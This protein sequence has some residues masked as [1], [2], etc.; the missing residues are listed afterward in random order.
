MEVNNGSGI[1]Q[2]FDMEKFFDKVSLIDTLNAL[3][4][5]GD[6][7]EKDYRMWF[8]LNCKTCISV[9]TTV[10]ESDAARIF[11]SI[12]QGSFGAALASSLNICRNCNFWCHRG[13]NFNRQ[14]SP[15]K[16]HPGTSQE[17]SNNYWRNFGQKEAKKQPN[18]IKIKIKWNSFK[19]TF[20]VCFSI[21][22]VKHLYKRIKC[23]KIWAISKS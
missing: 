1:F 4:V 23:L 2:G 6:I 13:Q 8:K 12:G 10:G 18:K 14:Y 3:Y 15:A 16:H 17:R 11:E 7:S 5:E 19:N 22:H 20:F 21:D 9:V